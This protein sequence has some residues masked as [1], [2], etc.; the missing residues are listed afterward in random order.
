MDFFDVE[1]LKKSLSRVREEPLQP[2][3]MA[4]ARLVRDL[5]GITHLDEKSVIGV[6][7][8]C[9]RCEEVLRDQFKDK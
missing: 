2:F 3:E 1:E 5:G 4:V 9:T 7:R 6:Y 8:M